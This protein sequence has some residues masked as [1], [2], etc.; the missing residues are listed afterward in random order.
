MNCTAVFVVSRDK[1]QV[2]SEVQGTE[3]KRYTYS[4]GSEFARAW[5]LGPAQPEIAEEEN[6]DR[7]YKNS[8][9]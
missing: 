4:Y 7:R 9:L 5:I 3:Y 2:S 8:Q 1:V 6:D